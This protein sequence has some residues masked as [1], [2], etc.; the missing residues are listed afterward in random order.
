MSYPNLSGGRLTLVDLLGRVG[1]SGKDGWTFTGS[2]KLGVIIGLLGGVMNDGELGEAGVLGTSTR[3]G[4]GG[5]DTG[6]DGGFTTCG[7]S[8]S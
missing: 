3:C 4:V 6:N 5:L 8:C 1:V 7:V 2:G